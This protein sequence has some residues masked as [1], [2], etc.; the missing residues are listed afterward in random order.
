MDRFNKITQDLISCGE[1][2]SDDQKVVGLLNAL[3]DKYKD[4]KNALEY[5]R[6]DLTVEIIHNSLRN[7]D[8]NSNLSIKKLYI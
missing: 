1:K 2:I 7:R 8:L 5:G 3:S 6:S 4:V